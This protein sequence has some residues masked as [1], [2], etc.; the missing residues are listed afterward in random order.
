M[1]NMT[2]IQNNQNT[3][4]LINAL[5]QAAKQYKPLNKEQ[6][7][8]LICQHKGNRDKLNELLFMHNIKL[9]F[10]LA[11]KYAAKSKDFDNLVQE[12]MKGLAEAAQRFDLE[13]G[14]KFVTYAGF[15]IRKYILA[16]FD[17]KANWIER[18]STSLNSPTLQQSGKSEDSDVTFE[19]F[20]NNYIEPSQD[21]HKTIHSELSSHEQQQ[22]CER[23]MSTLDD[24]ASLSATDKAVF[25]DYFYNKE[26]TRDIA[27]K[28]NIEIPRVFQIRNQILDKFR[29]ILHSQYQITSYDDV[30]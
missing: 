18:H 17:V 8:E 7:Q 9:V 19:N 5:K 4:K 20:I 13:K 6:E 10:N 25:V 23:L 11:K 3:T 15:W 26:K 21:Q 30:R 14:T 28:Y 27:A 2:V 22:L 29:D 1:A 12:G 24:D 16:T